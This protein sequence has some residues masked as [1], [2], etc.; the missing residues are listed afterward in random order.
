[1]K[2]GMVGLGRMGANMAERL[3][4]AERE[5]V[6]FDLHLEEVADLAAKGAVPVG[7]FDE[8]GQRLE[9][10]RAVRLMV[11]A[12][13]VDATISQ[14]FASRGGEEFADRPPSVLRFD[15][16]GHGENQP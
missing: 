13:G 15:F 9:V 11:P 7:S 2:V 12:A 6:A 14:R 4:R 16:G 10:P 3:L 1:M 8:L 5:I